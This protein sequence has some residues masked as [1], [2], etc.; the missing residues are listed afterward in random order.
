MV[1]STR[2]SSGTKKCLCLFLPYCGMCLSNQEK[3]GDKSL[4]CTVAVKSQLDLNFQISVK[5]CLA[6]IL[7]IK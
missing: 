6:I 2:D 5:I 4:S 1:I 7:V 3:E